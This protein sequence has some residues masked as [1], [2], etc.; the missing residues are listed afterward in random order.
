MIPFFMATYWF[1]EPAVWIAYA[2]ASFSIILMG[3]DRP[4]VLLSAAANS[5]DQ[6]HDR[7]S[8]DQYCWRVSIFH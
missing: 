7:S 1:E 4:E 8:A 3:L 5:S 2:R 6:Y